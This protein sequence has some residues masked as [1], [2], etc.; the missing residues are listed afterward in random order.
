MRRQVRNLLV[1]LFLSQGVP[2]LLGGDELGRTQ[3]GNNNAYAQDNEVSWYD[4]DRADTDLCEIRAEAREA[5]TEAPGVPPPSWFQGKPNI[6]ATTDD[7]EWF[8]P[9]ATPMTVRR[10]ARE[11]RTLAR[12]LPQR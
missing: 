1:T 7:I 3:G 6:G 5:S 8:T 12:G 11:L 4:W 9:S 10:L 2:M